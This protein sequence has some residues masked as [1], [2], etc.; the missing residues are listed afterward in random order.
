MNISNGSMN[1]YVSEVVRIVKISNNT[2]PLPKV[3]PALCLSPCP[4]AMAARGAPP[5]LT[6]A[7]NAEIRIM[8][9]PVTPI[10]ANA[11][12]PMPGIW[13]I[14]ILSTKLYNKFTICAATDGSA[15]LS[16]SGNIRSVPRRSS[17][18]VLRIF[19]LSINHLK[20]FY[21]ISRT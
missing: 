15:I 12:V 6:T 17:Y 4:R 20:K 3:F 9:A 16:T 11:S 13:P 19:L 8:I 21:P 10:P 5:P 7:E 14:Y 18:A 2:K 1:I